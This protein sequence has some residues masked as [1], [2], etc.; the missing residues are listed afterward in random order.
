MSQIVTI[1]RRISLE[2]LT[3]ALQQTDSFKLGEEQSWGF[4]LVY[5]KDPGALINFENGQIDVTSPGDDLFQ[6]LGS[7]ARILLSDVVLEDE[8]TYV[9][10]SDRVAEGKVILL[11][12]P[13]L[14]I[15]LGCLLIWR[16]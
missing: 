5:L 4:S 14:V 13:F 7:L 16:W 6:D 9:T 8:E 1:K 15:V 11:Y 10:Q 3:T 2:E 12:W